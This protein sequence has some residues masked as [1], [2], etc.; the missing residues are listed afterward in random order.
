M[1]LGNGVRLSLLQASLRD[2]HGILCGDRCV[3]GKRE[4]VHCRRDGTDR[5]R[6]QGGQRVD[7]SVALATL[8]LLAGIIAPRPASLGRLDTLTVEYSRRV[9]RLPSYPLPV[10]HEELMVDRLEHAIV[11]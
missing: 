1:E 6:G 8:H 7:K 2:D 9:V 3:I 5:A 4:P 10:E 11:P